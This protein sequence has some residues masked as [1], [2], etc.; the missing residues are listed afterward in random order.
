M[1]RLCLRKVKYAVDGR[2]NFYLGSTQFCARMPIE[3]LF[4]FEKEIQ[5]FLQYS[6]M[7][8]FL[9]K[10]PITPIEWV[11][12]FLYECV[13]G[14]GNETLTLAEFK[15]LLVKE[16]VS[17]DRITNTASRIGEAL[18]ADPFA[19]VEFEHPTKSASLGNQ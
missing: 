10:L 15:I 8:V 11:I 1:N 12:K 19:N 17:Y 2:H 16:N 4:R 9:A 7:R 5:T 3:T 18:F 13:V 6:N 14:G